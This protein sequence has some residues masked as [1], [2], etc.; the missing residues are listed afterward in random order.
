MIYRSLP[1]QANELAATLLIYL[2][3]ADELIHETK[4]RAL[5]VSIMIHSTQ[6]IGRL[7]PE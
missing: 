2:G 1:A 7:D 5:W 4:D 6:M 3:C